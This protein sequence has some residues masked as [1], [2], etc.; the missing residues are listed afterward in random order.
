LHARD[1]GLFAWLEGHLAFE[2]R[3]TRLAFWRAW[4]GVQV[5][6]ILGWALSIAATIAGGPLGAL[7]LA[8]TVVFYLVALAACLVRRLH[9]RGRSGW[10]LVPMICLPL[11][12]RFAAA[13][14]LASREPVL[15]SV[16]AVVSFLALTANLWVLIEIGMQESAP[17]NEVDRRYPGRP[18]A[19]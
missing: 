13:E 8:P 17:A 15:S 16:A 14:L 18:S 2:G 10:E 6:G 19:A 12:G 4:L 1:E 3:L 9:D 5:F 7:V 11:I